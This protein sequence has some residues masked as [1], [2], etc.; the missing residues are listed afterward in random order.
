M[1]APSPVSITPPSLVDVIVETLQAYIASGAVRPGDRLPEERLTD[2]LGVSRP[3]LREAMR[4]L[5]RDGI[6]KRLPNRGVI[7]APLSAKDAEE[8]YSL[9]WAL[10]RFALELALPI[11][12]PGRL[13]PL[14]TAILQ[15]RR[16]AGSDDIHGLVAANLSFH[17]AMCALP[18]HSRLMRAYQTLTAQLSVYMAA[19]LRF[20]HLST[21]PHDSVTRHER[22]LRLIEAGDLAAVNEEILRHGDRSFLGECSGP[23]AGRRRTGGVVAAPAEP[24]RSMED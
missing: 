11:E 15:M 12:D 16:S 14:R 24:M 17:T 9:R 18:G 20:R 4:L 19:N 2:R 1:D 3:P 21:G 22:L 8:I 10:E 13:E 5:E 6:L 7:V 23:A